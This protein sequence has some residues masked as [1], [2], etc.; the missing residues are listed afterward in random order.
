VIR[1]PS[2]DGSGG[3]LRLRLL[4]LLGAGDETVAVPIPFSNGA[5]IRALSDQGVLAYEDPFGKAAEL[6]VNPIDFHGTATESGSAAP[7]AS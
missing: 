5:W 2:D 1:L 7:A 6:C 4:S 3:T